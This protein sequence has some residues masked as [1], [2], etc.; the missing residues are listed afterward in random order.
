MIDDDTG[1]LPLPPLA[2][3][4]RATAA[5]A[6]LPWRARARQRLLQYLP[7][8][9]MALI[10]LATGWLLRQT[11]VP[12]APGRS[13]LPSGEP[14]YEMLRFSIQQYSDAG[15]ARGVI[16]GDRVRH[17]PG[18][19]QYLIDGARVRWTD[20]DGRVLH[21][22]A[23]RAIAEGDGSQVRL[24]GMARVVRD[25]VAGEA[26]PFEFTSESMLFDIHN[27]EVRSDV[28][29]RLRQGQDSFDAGSLIYHHAS[30]EVEL[31]GGVTGDVI[32]GRPANNR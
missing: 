5:L 32:S 2:A 11:P 23:T 30:R 14:D 12:D 7:I 27:G 20:T 24:E 6:R 4:A 15:P 3:S 13:T 18:S 19:D 17:Y 28:P 8:V 22:S 16:E 10:A 31:S 21:A 29:V 9:L 26:A 1:P 25:P